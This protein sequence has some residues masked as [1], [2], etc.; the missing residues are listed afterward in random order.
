MS[1]RQ[2]PTAHVSDEDNERQRQTLPARPQ[3][4]PRWPNE[5]NCW[6]R[7]P[8]TTSNQPHRGRLEEG[9]QQPAI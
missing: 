3:A 5:E 8:P 1:G 2:R 9:L 7:G 6:H 4:P